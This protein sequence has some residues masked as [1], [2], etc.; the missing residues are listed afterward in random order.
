M[1]ID[2]FLFLGLGLAALGVEDPSV[3]DAVFFLGD[4]AVINSCFFLKSMLIGPPLI[5]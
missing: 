3:A 1:F 4:F 2:D 5:A